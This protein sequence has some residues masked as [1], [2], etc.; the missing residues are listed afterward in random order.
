MMRLMMVGLSAATLTLG[1]CTSD[2]RVEVPRVGEPMPHFELE[3]VDGQ[4]R[5]FSEF[6]GQVALVNLWA[7]WCPPCRAETPLLQSMHDRLNSQG[8]EVIGITVDQPAARSAV[9]GFLSEYDVRY[10]QL[11]DPNMTTMD[12]F[13]VIGLPATY[14][15]G[16]DG[17]VRAVRMG[18]IVEGDAEFEAAIDEALAE[19]RPQAGA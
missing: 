18:P 3:S 4:T 19:P 9:D 11:L 8:F 15:V 6:E 10:T 17:V 2:M 7:T 5:A 14:L 12:R 16:R 1:A 13:G